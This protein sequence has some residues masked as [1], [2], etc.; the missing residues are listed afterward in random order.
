MCSLTRK[1]LW[2]CPGSPA[3]FCRLGAFIWLRCN[4]VQLQLQLQATSKVFHC[5][6][7]EIG[8]AQTASEWQS[9]VNSV[10]GNLHV[11]RQQRGWGSPCSCH[12]LMLEG[13]TVYSGEKLF[14]NEQYKLVL[15]LVRWSLGSLGFRV[16][17]N[18]CVLCMCMN[19]CVHLCIEHCSYR[20]GKYTEE[21]YQ[22]LSVQGLLE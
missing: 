5:T 8:N 16:C 1:H 12:P 11:F 7:G 9:C 15:W 13:E 6:R 22:P 10:W 3:C 17:A 4:S 18:V 20:R 14:I 21:D 2:P 19:V